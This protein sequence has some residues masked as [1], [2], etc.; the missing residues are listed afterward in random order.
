MPFCVWILSRPKEEIWRVTA[1]PHATDHLIFGNTFGLLYAL[2][3]KRRIR[4][5]L[6]NA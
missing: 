5:A 2:T 1:P 3:W 6:Q 4:L